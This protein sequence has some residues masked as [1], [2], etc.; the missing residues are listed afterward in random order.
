MTQCQAKFPSVTGIAKI[1]NG[2]VWYVGGDESLPYTLLTD[3]F[4]YFTRQEDG[5]YIL[6]M[7]SSRDLQEKLQ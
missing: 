3:T 7:T 6:A 4:Y 2:L 1:G 5:D